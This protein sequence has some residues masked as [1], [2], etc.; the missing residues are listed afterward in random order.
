[1]APFVGRLRT[2]PFMELTPLRVRNSGRSA[3]EWVQKI[4]S[5]SQQPSVRTRLARAFTVYLS[6]E[7]TGLR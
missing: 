7:A 1:M 4:D 2:D 6:V 3:A 5:C